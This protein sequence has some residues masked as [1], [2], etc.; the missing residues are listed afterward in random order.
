MKGKTGLKA[1]KKVE[2]STP[3]RACLTRE[4]GDSSPHF[5]QALLLKFLV[6][7]F[8]DYRRTNSP[9]AQ[10]RLVGIKPFCVCVC[11]TLVLL[12]EGWLI[13]PPKHAAE[14]PR[15]RPCPRRPRVHQR[16][17][18]RVS[19]R[20]RPAVRLVW[21][22]RRARYTLTTHVLHKNVSPAHRGSLLSQ[23]GVQR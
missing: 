17:G 19:V 12:V 16:V 18:L 10:A 22:G 14:E 11:R 21:S 1:W 8:Q 13:R 20:V 2:V 4:T 9:T 15:D 7:P 6:K 23:G 3:S 5:L